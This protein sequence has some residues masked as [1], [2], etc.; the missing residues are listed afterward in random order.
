MADA[1]DRIDYTEKGDLDD[2]VINDV[3]M[4]R[5]ERMNGGSFWIRCYRDGKPDVVFW[6]NSTRKISG[7][8]KIES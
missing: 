7:H 6:M 1:P 8:H 5:M 4:F 3:T 2:I